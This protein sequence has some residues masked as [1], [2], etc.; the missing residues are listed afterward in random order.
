MNLLD[1]LLRRKPRCDYL[2]SQ[3]RGHDRRTYR[4]Q[5][6]ANHIIGHGPWKLISPTEAERIAKSKQV[7]A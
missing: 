2:R 5:Q 3:Y 7:R 1:R 6:P 4:C